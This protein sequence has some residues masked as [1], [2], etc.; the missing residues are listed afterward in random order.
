MPLHALYKFPKINKLNN[1]DLLRL[2]AALQVVVGHVGNHLKINYSPLL[3]FV[4]YFPGVPI[5]FGI[6][7]FLITSSYCRNKNFGKYI[8]NRILRIYPA[9][10]FCFLVTCIL[11][12]SFK[13]I[14][15][16]YLFSLSFIKWALCQ[17]TFLQ[18]YTPV[19]LKS[20]GVGNPNGSLWTIVVELQFYL[21]LPILV[22]LISAKNRIISFF[23]ISVLSIFSI[24]LGRYYLTLN[25]ENIVT[26]FLHVSLPLYLHFFFLGIFSYLLWDKIKWLFEGKF[27]IWI[28]AY[29][30]YTYIFSYLL[31]WYEVSYYPNI[32]GLIGGLILWCSMLSF[33]FSNTYLSKKIL[34]ENDI[35]Y[36]V[37]IY[38]MLVI[39]V[40]CSFNFLEIS[41]SLRVALVFIITI[42]LAFLSWKIIEYPFLQMKKK[43]Y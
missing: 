40:M 19:Q 29:F 14:S 16:K 11:L 21:S 26:K 39:N 7:G 24:L 25:P 32:I 1:F 33:A 8:R 9:L 30:L 37:Y 3:N 31:K 18:F 43:I 41:P 20:W 13:V 10:W 6:S 28:T 22:H 38:H 2:L 27:L 36:G 5:F 42:I 12:I 35:S 15:F 23:S 17:I 34:K 4:F